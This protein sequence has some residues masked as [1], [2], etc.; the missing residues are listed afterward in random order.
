MHCVALCVNIIAYNWI[1]CTL[2]KY[3][4]FYKMFETALFCYN[5]IKEWIRKCIFSASGDL[6]EMYTCATLIAKYNHDKMQ[7]QQFFLFL[8]SIVKVHLEFLFAF[9]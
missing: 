9:E 4:A 7:C 6:Y 2:L 8:E 5:H 1:W 3:E